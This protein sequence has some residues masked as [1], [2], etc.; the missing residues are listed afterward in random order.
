MLRKMFAAAVAATSV[1]AMMPSAATAQ[2]W[3][4]SGSHAP[5]AY[6]GGHNEHWAERS[7]HDSH[8]Y[9]SRPGHSQRWGHAS[10]N[11]HYAGDDY[12]HSRPTVRWGG[13]NRGHGNTYYGH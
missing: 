8:G 13:H 11:A 10:G 1:T 7:R 5:R 6:E 4:H 3:G 12:Y 2:E 9:G